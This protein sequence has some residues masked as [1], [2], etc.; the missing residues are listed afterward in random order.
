MS[1]RRLAGRAGLPHWPA[2]DR[3]NQWITWGEISH[4]T[5]KRGVVD[6]SLHLELG[7]CRREKFLLLRIDGGY[8]VLEEMLGRALQGRFSALDRPIG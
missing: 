8:D 5:L 3:R 2:A 4:A 1:Q 6:H 7:D